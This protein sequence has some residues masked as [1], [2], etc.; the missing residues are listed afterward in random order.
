MATKQCAVTLRGHAG[1]VDTA[2]FSPDGKTLATGG[3]D[4]VVRLWN[5]AT[6]QQ[7]AVLGGY[8]SQ[9]W[10]VAFTPDGNTLATGCADGTLRLWRAAAFAETDRHDE[11]PLGVASR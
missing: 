8:R 11:A 1:A 9:V 10:S 4:N 3:G 2:A 6:R 7:V 5:V